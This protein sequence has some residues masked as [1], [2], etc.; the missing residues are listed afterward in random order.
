MGNTINKK[1]GLSFTLTKPAKKAGLVSGEDQP[2]GHHVRVYGFDQYIIVAG[3]DDITDENLSEIIV[4]AI[5]YT[6][7]AYSATDN[8]ISKVGHGWAV[9]L[10]PAKNAGFEADDELEAKVAPGLVLL[11]REYNHPLDDKLVS[12]RKSQLNNKN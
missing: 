2:E 1:K 6:K 10:A 7:T 11:K 4:T 9:Q 5:E 8:K 3:I 12:L